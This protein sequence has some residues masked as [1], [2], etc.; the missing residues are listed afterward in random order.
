MEVQIMN[1]RIKTRLLVFIGIT[2]LK[3]TLLTVGPLSYATAAENSP[4]VI[5]EELKD[6]AP[7]RDSEAKKWT[8][9]NWFK[10]EE[11]NAGVDIPIQRKNDDERQD[12]LVA[13]LRDFHREI[14]RIFDR[15]FRDFGFSSFGFDRPLF[16]TADG[17]LRPV[18]D[19]S[20]SDKEY[21]VTVEIP[22]AEKDDIKIE[23]S[24][25]VMTVRGEKKQKKEEKNKDHYRQERFYGSFQRVLSLPKDADQGNIKA[26]FRQGVLTVTMPKKAMPKPDVKEIPIGSD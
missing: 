14:D 20:A 1:S 2:V 8:P 7:N 9:W 12:E 21:T 15:T 10:K 11:R 17:M 13:P 19:L 24:N 18:T 6:A 16:L 5:T 4:D 26:N 22:G 3:V 25:N 23:V